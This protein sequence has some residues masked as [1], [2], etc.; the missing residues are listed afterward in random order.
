M[1]HK[2]INNL[3]TEVENM[4]LDVMDAEEKASWASTSERNALKLIGI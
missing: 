1:L 4:K 3:N 2:V